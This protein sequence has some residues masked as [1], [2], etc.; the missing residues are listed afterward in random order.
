MSDTYFGIS[1][2]IIIHLFLIYLQETNFKEPLRIINPEE[3]EQLK[4]RYYS[5]EIHRASFVLPRFVKKVI[6]WLYYKLIR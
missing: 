5:P 6:F 2:E 4:L 3:Q 1:M